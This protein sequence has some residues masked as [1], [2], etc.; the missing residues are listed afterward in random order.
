MKATEVFSKTC[1]SKNKKMHV[2][3]VVIPGLI[4]ERENVKWRFQATLEIQ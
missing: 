4:C 2:A 3:V 1:L